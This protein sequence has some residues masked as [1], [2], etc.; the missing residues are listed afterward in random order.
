MVH[1]SQRQLACNL[2]RLPGESEN[3][4]FEF[5]QELIFP[6]LKRIDALAPQTL[7]PEDAWSAISNFF[8]FNENACCRFI[9]A[10]S[11]CSFW[12]SSSISFRCCWSS[13]PLCL[14]RKFI[15]ICFF[16]DFCF[17]FIF[18]EFSLHFQSFSTRAGQKNWTR[19]FT[20]WTESVLGFIWKVI[21]SLSWQD[22][23]TGSVWIPRICSLSFLLICMVNVAFNGNRC[24]LGAL[25]NVHHRRGFVILISYTHFSL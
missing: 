4:F 7:A 13:S 11:I 8:N 14:R 25:M 20:Q 3:F 19:P 16:L 5:N 10:N 22:A 18:Q 24:L 12:A 23:L 21:M 1:C 15:S 2:A 17:G 6:C 9:S